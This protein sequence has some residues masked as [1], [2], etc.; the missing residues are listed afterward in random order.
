MPFS[1]TVG[2]GIGAAR[3][4]PRGRGRRHGVHP[5]RPLLRGPRQA[6][7]GCGAAGAARARRQ[8]RRVL[9]DGHEVRDPDRR[10]SSSAT[11][12]S[13]GRARRSPPTASSRKAPRPST[14][15]C[16]PASRCRSR[17][18][19]ATRSPAR[20][21]TP[22][23]A[24]SCAPPASV[25]TPR[26]RRSRG[27]STEAQTGKA[28]VQRLADRISAVFVPVVIALAVATLGFWLGDR[29]RHRA[30]AFTA[31][32]AVLI[33]A[34]PCALGLATPTALHGR[35]R[36]RRA[37]RHPH[38]GPGDPRVDAPGRHRR[39]RQ[40]RHR[41]DRPDGARRRRRRP[42]DIDATRCCGSPARS[43]TRPSTR[44]RGRSP[45]RRRDQLGDRSP[46]STAFANL[47]G[48]G[49]QGVVDGHAVVAGR[50][51]AARRLGDAPRRRRSAPRRTT[52]KRPGAPRSSS[53]GTA[54]SAAVLVV[55]DTVKP[56]SARRRSP[57]AR[58][59]PA[60]RCC[61]PATTNARPRAVAAQVGIDDVIAE[62]LP[63]GQG[64]RRSAGCRPTGEVV[65][66]VGD[67]VNDAAALAQADLGLAMGTGTDVAIEASDLTLVRGDLRAAVDAIRL[68]RADAGDDQ[69][70]PVLGVRLQRRRA[71]ARRRRPAQPDDRRRGDGALERV[72]R[73]E[74]PPAA[75]VPAA[76]PSITP[77]RGTI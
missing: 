73:L 67:G 7:L 59:R 69:G 11:G 77:E 75:P 52:P 29:R 56:T 40:D 70:Q 61:S 41:H 35:H 34:C 54:R 14:R 62:V 38:Q 2:R 37:A 33:I 12:S 60:R 36:P 65:A 31:A 20:R 32:V 9:R 46:R 26:S 63:G 8:G 57:A 5:R 76:I 16:S 39:A 18:V 50:R 44:S 66:M 15:R 48:L 64:R 19:P 13:S 24:S 49:V 47:E 10:S 28:P 6:P 55:A 71:A 45:P 30:T 1:L 4:L 27:S 42:A 25:P 68:S 72:R 21:S 53:A 17:S 22:A 51:A 58:A 74:Q 3:D 43:R 23:A